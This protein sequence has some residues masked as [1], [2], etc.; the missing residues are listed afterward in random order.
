MRDGEK[1]VRETV[2]L[3]MW[4]GPRNLSTA[5]MRS[6]AQRADAQVW[7]EPFYAAYLRATGLDHPMREEVIADGIS[8]AG[9]V[10]AACLKAPEPP[11][12][13]FY[14]KHMTHHMVDGFDLSWIDN[15]TNAFLIRAPERVLASYVKKHEDVRAE[16][17]GLRMQR[18]LFERAAQR[19]GSA[20]PVIDS[21]AI[22]AD[23]ETALAALCK[24]VGIGFD[25]AM[26]SW[27]AGPAPEDGIWG[28]HWYDAIWKSTG[29]APPETGTPELP[30]H[31]QRI[32]DETRADYEF[33]QQ[34]SIV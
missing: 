10:A 28:S 34:Y 20:P 29:F 17:I 21:T 32:A 14:Q 16:D 31:L 8:D 19:L 15:V 18:V 3:A 12:S 30:G 25:P 1:M 27:K 11:V 9:E 22:R 2:N 7:D 6:F 5:M 26:L 24:N 23:P 33:L 4:S 13:V